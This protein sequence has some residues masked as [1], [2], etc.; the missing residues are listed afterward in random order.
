MKDRDKIA[1]KDEALHN[2]LHYLTN[3]KQTRVWYEQY[4]GDYD[5]CG[6]IVCHECTLDS[7]EKPSF[8]PLFVLYEDEDTK[9][10][11]ER[12]LSHIIWL[13]EDERVKSLSNL[14]EE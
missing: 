13:L 9:D 3:A 1:K 12:I 11:A 6:K 14:A 10:K 7:E 2:R 8:N 5:R 4:M